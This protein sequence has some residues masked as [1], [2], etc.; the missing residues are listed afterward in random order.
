M[1]DLNDQSLCKTNHTL[2]ER[3]RDPH[4]KEAWQEFITYYEQFIYNILRH[5]QVPESDA[6]EVCQE[7]IIRLWKKLPEFTYNKDRGKFRN[8][9]GVMIRNE[10][11]RYFKKANRSNTFIVAKDQDQLEDQPQ[12]ETEYDI[13]KLIA[14]EWKQYISNLAWESI[15]GRFQENMQNVI[16]LHMDGKSTKEIAEQ[17]NIVESSVRVYIKRIRAHLKN[18]IDRYNEELL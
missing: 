17:C 1:P 4:N 5:L 13:D 18:E 3:V 12:S 6:E 8:W 15:K 7:I 2:L 11:N 10:A 9:L 14:D 16:L